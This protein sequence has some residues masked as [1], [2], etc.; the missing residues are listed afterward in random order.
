MIMTEE[1]SSVNKRG[2]RL[3]PKF[4]VGKISSCCTVYNNKRRDS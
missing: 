4:R 2:L 3:L 1:N